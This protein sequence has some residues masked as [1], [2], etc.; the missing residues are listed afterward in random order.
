LRWR[1]VR[2]FEPPG[3]GAARAA[4]LATLTRTPLQ[5]TVVI[6][7][8][9]FEHL[10]GGELDYKDGLQGAGFHISNP[11]ATRTCGCGESFS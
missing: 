11:N 6:D 5:V 10:S 2:Y 7:P 4:T 3:I 8:A 9:S 1:R